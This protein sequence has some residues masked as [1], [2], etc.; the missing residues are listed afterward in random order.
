[1][2]ILKTATDWAKAELLSTP[3]FILAGI[4]FAATS[5]GLWHLGKTDLARAYIIPTAVAGA[6]LIVIGT[7]LFF[8][9]KARV[10]NFSEEYNR[11]VQAFVQS[12]IERV[13]STIKEYTVQVFRI[14]PILIIAAALVFLFVSAPNWRA[15]SITT[16]AM[17]TIILF[18][19]GMAHARIAEYGEELEKAKTELKH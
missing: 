1:M 4:L 5:I 3:F 17:L 19:D 2:D 8:T 13:D 12:E 7:G 18:I 10:K 11:D 14:I 15:I 6:L 9:N 16:I